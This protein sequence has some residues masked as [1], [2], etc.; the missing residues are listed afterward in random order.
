MKKLV[1]IIAVVILAV[2]SLFEQ[3]ERTESSTRLQREI[4][5]LKTELGI[6]KDQDAKITSIIGQTQ[7]KQAEAFAKLREGTGNIDRDKMREERIKMMS[8]TDQKLKAVITPEQGVKLEAYRKK[9]AEE[10]QRR[11]EQ[12]GN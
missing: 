4:D 6:S 1:L 10:R 3:P 9:Q 7:K 2:G 12:R 11:I 5:N 8:E